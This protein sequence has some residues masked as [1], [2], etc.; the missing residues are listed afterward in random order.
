MRHALRAG[1]PASPPLAL[2]FDV[3]R[4]LAATGVLLS[5]VV[6]LDLWADYNYRGIHIIGPLFLLNAI[7]GFVIGLAGI[8]W[9]HWLPALLAV[10]FGATTLAA[11]WLSVELN[12]GLFGF[13]EVA[14][15]TPQVVAEVSEV[16]AM[17]FGVAAVMTCWLD[18]RE[19]R[20]R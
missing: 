15:G 14:S 2:A 1:A 4:G 8:V 9:R 17:V 7:G 20:L 16:M 6:H 5:A 10:G 3:C 13:K 11:F 12:N 19:Q 18:R